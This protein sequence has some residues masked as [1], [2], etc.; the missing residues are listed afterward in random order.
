MLTLREIEPQ[1]L[2]LTEKERA[3]LAARLLSSLPPVLD[4]EDE[5]VA[6]ALRREAEIE[7]D[8]K[9][10]I[11]LEEFKEGISKLRG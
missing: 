10:S 8:P 11:S 1:A 5:G 4:D 2:A 6:E 3:D 7:A 9:A